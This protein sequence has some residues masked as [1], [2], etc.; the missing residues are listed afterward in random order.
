MLETV[1]GPERIAV[2]EPFANAVGGCQISKPTQLFRCRTCAVCIFSRLRSWLLDGCG[3]FHFRA[4]R[5]ELRVGPQRMARACVA[6]KSK[7]GMTFRNWNR[8]RWLWTW[9]WMK[10]ERERRNQ[11]P[12]RRRRWQRLCI[13]ECTRIGQTMMACSNQ[14]LVAS[15]MLCVERHYTG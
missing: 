9:T 14:S 3:S 5:A 6:N 12:Q 7:V 11:R 13:N 2:A 4:Q 15:A 8:L 10:R 1:S